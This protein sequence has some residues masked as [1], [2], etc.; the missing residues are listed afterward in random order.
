VGHHAEVTALGQPMALAS[1]AEPF[2][3]FKPDSRVLMVSSGDGVLRLWD[4]DV[5]HEAERICTSTRGALT[6]DLWE[7]RLPQVK[8]QNPC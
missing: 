3:L 2:V 1:G 8:F 4:L 5:A 7:A 6:K